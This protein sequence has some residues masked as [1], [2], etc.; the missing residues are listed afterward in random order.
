MK[1]PLKLVKP[2]ARED[3][4]INAGIKA[5]PDTRELTAEDFAQMRPF[6]RGRPTADVHKVPVTVRLDPEIVEFFRDS[7]RGWQ[8]RMNTALARYVDRQRRRA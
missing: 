8:S 6:R 2:T 3:R 5:D 1:K 7:G 4:A